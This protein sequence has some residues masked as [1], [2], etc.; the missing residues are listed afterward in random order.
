MDRLQNAT[1]TFEKVLAEAQRQFIITGD[2][3]A[4]KAFVEKAMK[5]L[6]AANDLLWALDE[7]IATDEVKCGAV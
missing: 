1:E 6:G 2:R 3:D 5:A 7:A 4:A